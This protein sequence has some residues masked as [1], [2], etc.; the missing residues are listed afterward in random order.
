MAH[1][2][3]SNCLPI[4][5]ASFAGRQLGAKALLAHFDSGT[6]DGGRV[7]FRLGSVQVAKH[8]DLRVD[9]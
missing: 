5:R 4:V 9:T 8:G 3:C 7:Q 1:T 2:G 6:D